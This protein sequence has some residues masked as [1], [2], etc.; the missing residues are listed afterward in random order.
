MRG[1]KHNL[2]KSIHS[3]VL[4]IAQY[5]W[6]KPYPQYRWCLIVWLC[7]AGEL[8]RSSV[9]PWVRCHKTGE[10]D[11][12][13]KEIAQ[14]HRNQSVLHVIVL[15]V[16]HARVPTNREERRE[17][18]RE[19][20]MNIKRAYSIKAWEWVMLRN[21][22]DSFCGWIIYNHKQQLHGV[23]HAILS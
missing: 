15:V 22:S 4:V 6:N 13:T 18:E 5:K 10:R 3:C 21:S 20:T 12:A 16:R 7:A 19:W 8:K 9:G 2:S 23:N 1:N 11:H 14:N 17:R